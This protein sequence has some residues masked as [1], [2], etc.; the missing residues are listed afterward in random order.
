MLRL[1]HQ[2]PE[3]FYDVF[4]SRGKSLKLCRLAAVKRY[5]LRIFANPH[6]AESKIRLVALLVELQANQFAPDFVH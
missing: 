4:E 5:A 2:P 1:R 6:H 3:I